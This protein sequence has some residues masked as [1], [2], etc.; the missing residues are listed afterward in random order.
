MSV[1]VSARQLESDSLIDDV[2][3]AL[4]LSALRPNLLTLEI[5]ETTIMR[6]A[7]RTADRLERLR[8]LGVRIAIDDFGTGYCSL[9][10]LRRFPIDVLKI[11]RSFVAGL[12]ESEDARA[13]VR[14]LVRL[15]TDLGLLTLAEGI[16]DDEQLA[17]LRRE[18][19]ESGQGFLFAKPLDPF[20]LEDLLERHLVLA[21]LGTTNA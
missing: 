2:R 20:A 15:G 9:S 5:T 19:C 12:S 3:G 7:D 8:D 1:N 18:H 11:D 10:Y 17:E 13:L 14:T 4:E 16:E 21:A 6:D